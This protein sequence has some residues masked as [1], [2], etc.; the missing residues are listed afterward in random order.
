MMKWYNIEFNVETRETLCRVEAFREW[1]YDN[2][3]KF[4]TSG[5]GYSGVHFEIE[6]SPEQVPAVNVAL[7]RLVWFD[8]ITEV[9]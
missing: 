7:D 6:L 1:L 8:S 5:V 2:N 3:V 9:A 4:E